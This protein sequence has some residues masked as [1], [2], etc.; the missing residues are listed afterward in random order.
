MIAAQKQ[1][2]AAVRDYLARQHM[3]RDEFAFR[4][5][6]GRSTVDKFL[7][8]LF[9]QRTLAIV[10]DHT[11][12]ALRPILAGT[13]AP[14]EGA[15]GAA[16]SRPSIA[17]L[18]FANLSADPAHDFF[19]DG[20]AGDITASLARLRWLFVIARGSAFAYRGRTIDVRTVAGELGVR[21]LLEGSVQ[22]AGERLRVTCELLDAETAKHIW[23]E[24]YD[25]ELSDVFAVQDDIASRVVAAVEPH[26]YLEEGCR[27]A[28]APAGSIDVWG[29][30][31]RAIDFVHRFERARNEEACALLRRAIALEPEYARAHAMLG[32]AIWW[33]GHCDWLPDRRT[34]QAE[35]A[36]HAREA[37]RFDPNDPWA[38]MVSGLA[39]S[40]AGEHARAHEELTAALAINPSFA[41]GHSIFGWTLLRAG[42]TGEAIAETED[43]L[44]LSPVDSFSGLYT[45]VHGLALIAAR[46]FEE[47][48]P[49]L[50]TSVAAFPDYGGHYNSLICCC[51][52][53][54]LV[55][56]AQRFLAAR[57][58]LGPPLRLATVR[59]HL[60]PFAHCEVF[61]EGLRKAGVED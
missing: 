61:L 31:V 45:S 14:P 27:A 35:A 44:R 46:R 3:S 9:S 12:L 43:A 41:L 34:A 29:L 56:E 51:G 32:W 8:G 23:S 47:A 20:I 39:F 38:R 33:A 54:G 2:A 11:R 17:V 24:R 58:A 59:E 25:R 28:R 52:H 26:L 1:V 36:G 48:L 55:D 42:R 7:V 50:R 30:V 60:A 21:Y 49:F 22:V 53:L 5:K 40:S 19:A 13:E 57:N 16:A 15:A 6:L 37:L 10:E 18:P 4:T